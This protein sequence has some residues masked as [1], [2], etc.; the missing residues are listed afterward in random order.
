MKEEHSALIQELNDVFEKLKKLPDVSLVIGGSVPYE[1]K[2][3]NNCIAACYGDTLDI[4]NIIHS[5]IKSNP[6]IVMA[7]IGIKAEEDMLNMNVPTI[8]SKPI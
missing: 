1:Q 7:L 4:A 3:E 5:L 2:E 8:N 6:L